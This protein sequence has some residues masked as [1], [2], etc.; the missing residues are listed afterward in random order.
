MGVQASPLASGN[1]RRGL[2]DGL[3]LAYFSLVW[4]F[5][6]TFV[7]LAAGIAAS[8]VAL[9]GFGLDSVVEGSSATI[10]IWRLRAERSGSRSAEQAE[11]RAIGLV[12][13][14]F[15]ALA[16]YIGIRAVY[17]LITQV[18]P[19][20]STVGIIL[21]LVSLIVMPVL[22]WRKRKIAARLHSRSLEA[23]AM[24]TA[25]CT[26]LSA[27]LLVG[28]LA[29]SLFGWWWA[30]PVAGLAIAVIAAREG[31]ELRHAEELCC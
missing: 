23:D 1:R 11:T 27:F 28:L 2:D 29:N 3:R 9:V 12:S 6:E 16:A 31:L 25:L 15:L 10:V 19:E 7:G 17:D 18:R 21:A 22:A 24:Q 14:A 30:D 8:S 13:Y 20:E 26:Y 4:N 5:L